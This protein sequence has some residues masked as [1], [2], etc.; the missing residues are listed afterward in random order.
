MSQSLIGCVFRTYNGDCNEIFQEIVT[1]DGLCFTFNSLTPDAL[2]ADSVN[3]DM[4][5]NS[6]MTGIFNRWTLED[7]YSD[8]DNA[9]NNVF[10]Y[11]YRVL[12][13]GAK[14]GLK[15]ALQLKENDMEY[16]CRGPVQGFKVMLHTPNE[17]PAVDGIST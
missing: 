9:K 17:L 7:G 14:A 5:S 8:I 12:N 4:M 10:L 3:D 2:F 13:T 1:D 15:V 6:N 11:P 16:L